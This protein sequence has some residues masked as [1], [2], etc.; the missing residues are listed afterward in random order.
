MLDKLG[1]HWDARDGKWMAQ[2]EKLKEFKRKFSH[3]NVEFEKD[4]YAPLLSWL[5]IQR[6]YK[7]EGQLQTERVAMLDE[8]GVAW[9]SGDARDAKWQAMYEQLK[10]YSIEY[11]NSDVPH[12]S[13]D[14]RQLAAWVGSQRQ[15]RKKNLLLDEQIRLLDEIGF[16][17]KHRDRGSWEDRLAEVIAF[18]ERHGHC[19]IPLTLTDPPKLAAFVNATRVQRNKGTLSAERI[20][21]LD[22]VGFVWQGITTKIA[23]DGMNEVWRERFDE[24]LEYKKMH[25]HCIV[26]TS[27]KQ[28]PR[29][30]NWVNQ[31]RILKKNGTLHPERFRLLDEAGFKWSGTGA[32]IAEDGMADIWTERFNE[33]LQYKNLYGNCRVPTLWAENRQLG[34]WVVRQRQLKKNGKLLL[35]RERLLEDAGFEWTLKTAINKR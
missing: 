17:W 21:K 27:S 15:Q 32:K 25:G 4:G 14:N 8:L 10:K 11:G 24:L 23:E 2:F 18:K 6:S 30:G 33:L 7:K 31:Q 12:L 19:N 35:E 3:C 29:L 16:T 28:N 26:S 5:T 1:F 9:E 20:T 13:Q 34:G 22:A